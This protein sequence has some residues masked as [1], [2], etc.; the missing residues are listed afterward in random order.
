MTTAPATTTTKA[1]KAAKTT[2]TAPVATPATVA[3][4]TPLH[5][6][7]TVRRSALKDAMAHVGRAIAGKNTLPVLSTVQLRAA[8]GTLV[9]TAT[10][11]SLGIA[12]QIAATSRDAW[13]VCIPHKLFADIVGTLPGDSITIEQTR[14]DVIRLTCG[15]FET[16]INGFEGSEFPTLPTMTGTPI[17][18]PGKAF[19]RAMESVAPFAATDHTRPILNGVW[20]RIA[21][22]EASFTAADGFRLAKVTIPLDAA[23]DAIQFV[24]P[25]DALAE[26]AALFP[27]Q[28]GPIGMTVHPNGNTVAFQAGGITAITR[29]L[30]GRYPDADRIIPTGSAEQTRATL[31]TAELANAFKLAGFFASSSSQ[32]SRA[33]IGTTA[34]TL[35][36]NAAS[37]GDQRADVDATIE[38]AA[39]QVAFNVKFA[40]QITKVID[41]P[42][43]TVTVTSPTSPIVFRPVGTDQAIFLLMP[44]TVQ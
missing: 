33:A 23:T 24:T 39:V 44:M 15:G 4:P 1:T 26:I 19:V 11:L 20:I 7:V 8:D 37:V 43:L 14:S 38:G 18:L 3:A 31:N 22:G 34:L 6:T 36:A 16:T 10:D 17:T 25:G 5:P 28:D 41:T 29:M 35:T 12:V 13:D 27:D 32:I 42:T 30:E 9:L 2:T 40:A 21:H